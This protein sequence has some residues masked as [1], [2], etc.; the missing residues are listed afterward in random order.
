MCKVI[1]GS[2]LQRSRRGT[3]GTR[4]SRPGPYDPPGM[5]E[6]AAVAQSAA[7]AQQVRA[8]VLAAGGSEEAIAAAFAHAEDRMKR[9]AATQGARKKE[10]GGAPAVFLK[11][12][13]KFAVASRSGTKSVERAKTSDTQ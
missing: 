1:S 12:G 5:A 9:A 3:G 11:T 2:A 8:A 10:T 7:L 13:L 4:P 6:F